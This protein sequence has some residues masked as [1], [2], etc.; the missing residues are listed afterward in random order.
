MN[1]REFFLSVALL[2]A[3][4]LPAGAQRPGPDLEQA[5]RQLYLDG[6]YQHVVDT[7]RTV[8]AESLSAQTLSFLGQAHGAL[9]NLRLS[10]RC[11]EQAASRES[12]LAH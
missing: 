11:L 2:S 3:W 5:A 7:L 1:A 4:A 9:Q 12:S 8:P 10:L 6:R